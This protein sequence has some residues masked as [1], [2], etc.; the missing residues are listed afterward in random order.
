MCVVA[1][2]FPYEKELWNGAMEQI[3]EGWLDGPAPF[4]TEGR[5]FAGNSPQAVNP[6]SRSGAPQGEKLMAVDDGW[7]SSCPYARK[8]TDMWQFGSRDENVSGR[9]NRHMGGNG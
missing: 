5:L 2:K 4:D 6:T 9:G 3:E 1:P 7:S 8:L